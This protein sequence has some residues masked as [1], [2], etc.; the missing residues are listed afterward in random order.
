MNLGTKSNIALYSINRLVFMTEMD[1]VYWTVRAEY[2]Y[3]T[4]KFRLE[5]FNNSIVV[6]NGFLHS[7]NFMNSHFHF[8][9]TM[10][11]ATFQA[12]LHWRKQY[13]GWYR[14]SQWNE[15]N[16]TCAEGAVCLV[17]LPCR[18]I[19]HIATDCLFRPLKR[20]LGCGWT[21]S[22]KELEMVVRELVRKEDTFLCPWNF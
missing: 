16:D 17:A 3:N 18:R 19:T 7:Q 2:L 4:D 20:C 10:A 12:L 1:S 14:S 6:E 8:L 22:N 11:S 5:R 9:I 21:H 15:Y 13:C